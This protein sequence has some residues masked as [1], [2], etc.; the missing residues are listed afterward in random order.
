MLLYTEY[1]GKLNYGPD[2]RACE[3][4]LVIVT[5]RIVYEVIKYNRVTMQENYHSL[6]FYFSWAVL[7]L[8]I[9][10]EQTS[11]TCLVIF[12]NS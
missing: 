4:N 3:F 11:D 12:C 2:F 8:N 6:Y 9:R 10:N 5:Y 1:Q 7:S